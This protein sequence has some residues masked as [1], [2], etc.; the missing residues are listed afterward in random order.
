MSN[1]RTVVAVAAISF[2]FPPDSS[3]FLFNERLPL[4]FCIG[5]VS[6]TCNVT[7]FWHML[8]LRERGRLCYSSLLILVPSHAFLQCLSI[9][10]GLPVEYLSVV[11]KFQI[12]Y[13][14]LL[15]SQRAQLLICTECESVWVRENVSTCC[16]CVCV[17]IYINIIGRCRES[18][19]LIQWPNHQVSMATRD[20]YEFYS[21]VRRWDIPHAG[22]E[23][24]CWHTCHQTLSWPL[25]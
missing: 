25:F 24:C 10:L 6:F 21:A 7:Y 4:S 12:S 19:W 16:L 13:W 1:V 20:G 5:E 3:W 14:M 22:Q 17:C 8:L 2:Y 15:I 18:L 9:C 23:V 11:K